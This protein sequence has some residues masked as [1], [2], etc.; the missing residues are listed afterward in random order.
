MCFKSDVPYAVC[1]HSAFLGLWS[2]PGKS[3]RFVH[4][5]NESKL[6]AVLNDLFSPGIYFLSR[7]VD[8]P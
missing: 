6:C 2:S 1:R 8:F 4:L 7:F 3:F 5:I